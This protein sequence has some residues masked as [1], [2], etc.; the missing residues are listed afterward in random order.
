[1]IL[2]HL[3]IMVKITTGCKPVEPPDVKENCG[4]G[5]FTLNSKKVLPVIMNKTK[6][7]QECTWMVNLQ[8]MCKAKLDCELFYMPPSK[9]I[10]LLNI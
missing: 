4:T 9:G 2:L 3:F 6:K 1:M 7:S 8:S 10:I 5:I